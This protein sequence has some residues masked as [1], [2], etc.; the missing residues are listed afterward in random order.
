VDLRQAH[1]AV[2]YGRDLHLAGLSDAYVELQ[3]SPEAAS[4]WRFRK[5]D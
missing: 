3:Q 5:A 2:Q 4:R 1:I